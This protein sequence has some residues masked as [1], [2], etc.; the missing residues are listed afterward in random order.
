VVKTGRVKITK[1]YQIILRQNG[2]KYTVAVIGAQDK[3]PDFSG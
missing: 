3:M 1:H 2:R